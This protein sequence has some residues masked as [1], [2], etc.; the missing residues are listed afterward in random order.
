MILVFL[1]VAILITFKRRLLGARTI[2]AVAEVL[3]QVHMFIIVHMQVYAIRWYICT[4]PFIPYI[5]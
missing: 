5:S 2:A 1:A 4:V 3:T